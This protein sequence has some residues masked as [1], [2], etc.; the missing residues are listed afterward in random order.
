MPLIDFVTVGCYRKGALDKTLV[1]ARRFLGVPKSY[2]RKLTEVQKKKDML[3]KHVFASPKVI[4]W[5]A[6]F[7]DIK[8]DKDNQL[9]NKVLAAA[10]DIKELLRDLLISSDDI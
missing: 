10:K 5:N 9:T 8:T 1:E 6:W 7:F 3:L 4:D 2:V